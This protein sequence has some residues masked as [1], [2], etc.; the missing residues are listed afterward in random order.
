MKKIL[1]LHGLESLPGGTKPRFLKEKGYEVLNPLMPRNSFDESC[2]IAQQLVIQEKPDIVIGSSRGGA[3][4]LNINV[5]DA[6]LILI[7]PA[8]THYPVNV[9]SNLNGSVILHSS[10]DD[11]VDL[12]DSLKLLSNGARLKVCGK[13]HRMSDDDCLNNL[14][15]FIKN[16]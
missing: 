12:Q 11:I 5:A 16:Y 9:S 6:K 13:D 8:W 7:A 15:N 3:V 10:N 2:D 14:Y 4:A 1:F